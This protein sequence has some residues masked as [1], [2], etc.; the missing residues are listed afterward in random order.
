[1]SG[2]RFD[3]AFLPAAVLAGLILAMWLAFYP[4]V[5][6]TV[7]AQH[8]PLCKA[9]PSKARSQQSSDPRVADL[10]LAGKIRVGLGLG[11]HASAMKD[12]ATGEM[13]GMASDLAR[14]LAARI[15]VALEV[16]EYPRPGAVFDG[17]QTDAWDVTFLV[18]DPERTAEA[19]VSPAYMQSEFTYLVPAGS[20]IRDVADA[21]RPGTSIGVP[22][23]DAV[24]L[25]LSR[26][27]K[28]ATLVRA[29]S[30]AA[31]IDLLR[32]GSGQCLCRAALGAA[33]A[34]GASAGLACPGRMRL[35]RRP[36]QRSCPKVTTSDW[37]T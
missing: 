17:A 14:A 30:Q 15:G 20:T 7:R 4:S 23:G 12:P 8:T 27:L 9:Q 2:Q 37:P 32:A 34:V 25:S 18:I 3:V 5:D 31:G 22:R 21:D 36:G 13:H 1:M 19:D 28:Q 6:T 11:N 10:V 29:E 35:P 26:I 24:D 33:R 16:V